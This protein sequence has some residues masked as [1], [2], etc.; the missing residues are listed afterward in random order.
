MS[1]FTDSSDDDVPLAQWRV[2]DQKKRKLSKLN[3]KCKPSSSKPTDRV[4]SSRS[5]SSD[6]ESYYDDSDIDPN[7]EP[8][9]KS[10]HTLSLSSEGEDL[11]IIE[12]VL[13]DIVSKVTENEKS[14][15]K[16]TDVTE[17]ANDGE[18]LIGHDQDHT[19]LLQMENMYAS[20]YELAFK[21]DGLP[22]LTVETEQVIVGTKA[23]RRKRPNKK[24]ISKELYNKGQAYT[25]CNLKKY[26]ARKVRQGCKDTCKRKCKDKISLEQR[27]AIST[28]YWSLGDR[29]SRWNFIAKSV[30]TVEPQWR[31]AGA[32]NQKGHTKVYTFEVNNEEVNVCKTFFLHTLDVTENVVKTALEKKNPVGLVEKHKTGIHPNRPHALTKEEL[33]EI[34]SHINSFP[35]VDSHYCRK[36]TKRQYLSPLLSIEEM[37]RLYVQQR[38]GKEGKTA[39]L[40]SYKRVFYPKNLAFHRPKKD[41]C[42][43]CSGYYRASV[44]TEIMKMNHAL[45]RAEVDAVRA[46]RDQVKSEVIDDKTV[47]AACFDLEEVLPIPKANEGEIYYKRQLNNYN[48][49]VYGFHDKSGH[50]YLWNETCAKR[51]ANDIGSCVSKYLEELKTKHYTKVKLL[52]D[53][54]GGQNRNRP[55]MAMLWW[56]CQILQFEEISHTFFVRGHSENE[57]DSIHSCIE[58]HSKHID[59]YTTDQWATVIQGAKKTNPRYQV[60]QM[61]QEDFLDF[62]NFSRS[63]INM[64]KDTE[65]ESVMYTKIRQYTVRKGDPCVEI[66]YSMNATGEETRQ[67]DLFKSGRRESDF[68]VVLDLDHA[69]SGKIA[70]DANKV[71]DL[72]YMCANSIIPAAYHVFF[73]N[74]SS[75]HMVQ[76]HSEYETDETDE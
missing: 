10:K 4:I 19:D 69:Y 31:R 63:F 53:S 7:Y 8:P 9:I 35:K 50:N 32:I 57:C 40:S 21:D 65:K 28:A 75:T 18:H 14:L 26:E 51:G 23:C 11:G 3:P 36:T 38:Q 64:N 47:A 48:L 42:S 39:S 16:S 49:S 12:D 45:H 62:K 56:A 5:N 60:S 41:Q 52:S 61:A 67:M 27:T 76:P 15:K 70:L 1:F 68:N 59:V 25:G 44:K 43:T 33:L 22:I 71:K 58:R 74:I 73:K 30:K 54:A 13:I 6:E 24:V 29:Q 55:F 20:E 46:Y 37:Y 17:P 34:N 2:Q 72:M 66:K